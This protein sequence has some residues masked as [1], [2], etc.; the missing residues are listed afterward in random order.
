MRGITTDPQIV[1]DYYNNVFDQRGERPT[2]R[3]V[4]IA[5]QISPAV[6][7]K[8]VASNEDKIQGK[9]P[10]AGRKP[11]TD[12]PFDA[13]TMAFLRGYTINNG[14]APSQ[15]EVADAVGCSVTKINALLARLAAE[16]LIELGPHPRQIKITGS[17]L[18]MPEITL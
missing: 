17:V 8:A 3:E 18:R 16:G 15:R 10:D 6:V 9:R 7:S 13:K 11:V 5:L 14:W 12:D 2:Q 1:V 4:A